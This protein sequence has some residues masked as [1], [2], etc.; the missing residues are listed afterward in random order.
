MNAS[1]SILIATQAGRE[2]TLKP[3]PMSTMPS[4][5]PQQWLRFLGQHVPGTQLSEDT[6]N[7]LQAFMRKHH[8]EALRDSEG[9][10]YT[11]AGG[12]L[13]TCHPEAV[14]A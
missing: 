9:A 11:L 6:Q 12:M 3:V 7:R 8:S 14:E 5:N 4:H 2:Y 13:A 10:V 1:P